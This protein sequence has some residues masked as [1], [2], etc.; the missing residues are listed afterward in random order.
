MDLYQ[1]AQFSRLIEG[2]QHHHRTTRDRADRATV[3]QVLDARTRRFLNALKARGAFGKLG[4]CVSTGKEANV[5]AATA[6][7]TGGAA[8]QLQQQQGSGEEEEAEEEDDL[9]DEGAEQDGEQG[10]NDAE[11]ADADSAESSSLSATASQAAPDAVEVAIKIYKTSILVFKDRSKYVIGE[12][13]FSSQSK[14]PRQMV[15]Q[16]A[17]KEFR[18]LKRLYQ[19]PLISSPRPIDIKQNVLVMQYL[20][21]DQGRSPSPKLRDHP[22]KDDDEVGH[23]YLEMLVLMRVLY[24]RCNLIHADLSEY[25]TIVHENELY[26]FDVSQSVEPNHPMALDFLR[27][28]IKNINDFFSRQRKINVYSERD[29][30][31]FIITPKVLNVDDSTFEDDNLLKNAWLDYLHQLP[32]KTSEDDDFNDQIFRSLH[33]ITSLHQLDDDD[34]E[35]FKEIDTLGELV[36]QKKDAEHSDAQSG[37]Q[38]DSDEDSDEDGDSDSD[39]EVVHNGITAGSL[40]QKKNQDKSQLKAEKAQMKEEKREKRKSKM[41]KHLKKRLVKKSSNKKG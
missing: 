7:A 12:H 18:N 35:N 10:A 9:N 41:K 6:A 33:L 39:F 25:N 4:D 15:Q 36:D 11:Q 32:L 37:S 29:I 1:D 27:M 5:Y 34:Y 26:V 20:T 19:D 13:R 21:M 31:N 2:Q 14:N 22:F 17:E 40:R 24:Q 16:W 23:Y 3:N 38:F 30:F 28:D 8:T